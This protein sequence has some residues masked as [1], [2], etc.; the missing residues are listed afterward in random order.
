MDFLPVEDQLL[1]LKRGVEEIIPEEELRTKLL[2]AARTGKPLVVKLGCDPSRPD[3]HLG[4]SVVLRKLR[5]FQDLG[6]EVVLIVGDFTG[7][8]GDASGR[9]KMRP[10]L[11]LEETRRNGQTYFE[12]ASRILDSERIRI[13]YNSEWLGKLSFGDVVRLAGKST[14]ARMLE[15][16]DFSGRYTKGDP[17][18]IHEF[19]YP[20]A[21]AQD[22]VE[23]E[24]DVELGGT[25]Q[26]FNLL[27]GRTVQKSVGQEPQ[28]CITLPILEGLDGAEKMSKSLDNYVGLAEPAETMYGK[29]LSIPDT[30]I[31][32]YFE[33]ASDEE[34]DALPELH[35]LCAKNPRDAKHRLALSITRFYHGIEAAEKAREH[36]ER[37]VIRKEV[38]KE[39]ASFKPEGD[40]QIGLLNLLTSSGLTPSNG[41]ARRLVQQGAVSI[42]GQRVTDNRLVID[43]TKRAPFLVKVGKRRFVRIVW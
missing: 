38:P 24:A 20:L 13:V 4:H 27:M 41:A 30:L 11:S 33:L 16:D 40:G 37:T 21:Q 29:I 36:F 2:R 31:Y 39:V 35:K 43:V 7:M 6:H 28:V 25:D 5:Q 14:V 1:H 34:T 26:K 18:G 22:S 12:Q 10:A 23:I 32:R 9:S 8:I 42:D 3:L 17:I 15:R 19:L